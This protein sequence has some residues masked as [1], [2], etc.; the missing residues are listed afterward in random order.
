M[1]AEVEKLGLPISW[2]ARGRESAA[3][4]TTRP[5]TEREALDVLAVLV[6]RA[7]GLDPWEVAPFLTEA[8]EHYLETSRGL[9]HWRRVVESRG[10][11]RGKD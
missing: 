10:K 9:A 11:K 7:A 5:A 1:A 8:V 4:V 6:G 3:L 2:E